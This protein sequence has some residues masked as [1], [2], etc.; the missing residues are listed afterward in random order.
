MIVLAQLVAS[1]R[2]S[3]GYITYVF[4]CLEDYMIA[5]KIY[6]PYLDIIKYILKFVYNK[7]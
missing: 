6:D 2:D 3:L 7:T 4:E 5:Q 1:E